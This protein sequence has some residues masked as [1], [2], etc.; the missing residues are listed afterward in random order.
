V[1]LDRIRARFDAEMRLDP[2]LDPGE[3]LERGER[4]VRV[5]GRSAWVA[6][7]ALNE[8]EAAVRVPAEAARS[9]S[10]GVEVEWKLFGYDPPPTLPGLL[11]AS[12]FVAD[13]PETLMVYD[14]L[15]GPP[16]PPASDSVE[17]RRSGD[18]TGLETAV[19][20]SQTAFAPEPGWDVADYLPRLGTPSFEVFVATVDGRP[21]SAGRLELP[22]GRAFA[23][24]WGGGTTPEFRGRG[25]YRALVA[26]RADVARA[27]GYRY[28]T[29]DARESSRPILERVGFRPLATIVGWV[30]TP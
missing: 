30:L 3:R 16:F 7:S 1:D 4:F 18:R 5:V 6:Y 28:L 27:R 11:A 22:E 29:V 14:L 10:T 12:G 23:S 24:L 9:R 20:V 8:S 2:P 26:A 21:V 17:V 25:V 15:E 13:P 19:E